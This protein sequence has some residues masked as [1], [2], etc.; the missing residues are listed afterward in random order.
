[1]G[2]TSEGLRPGAH[3]ACAHCGSAV[4]LEEIGGGRI[5]CCEAPMRGHAG[6]GSGVARGRARCAGCGNQV[7]IERDGGG[8]LE[9]C[10][11]DMERL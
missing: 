3:L 2:T 4:R 9:C 7:A 10:N 5:E 6:A 11:E 1:M 8:R